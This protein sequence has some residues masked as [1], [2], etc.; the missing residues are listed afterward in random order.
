MRMPAATAL[1]AP[2]VKSGRQ[3]E[4]FITSPARL[5][6]ATHTAAALATKEDSGEPQS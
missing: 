2:D 6:A 4:D 3:Q 1:V 5:D